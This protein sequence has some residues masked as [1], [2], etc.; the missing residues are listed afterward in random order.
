MRAFLLSFLVSIHI[1]ADI[2]GL[3]L[4]RALHKTDRNPRSRCDCHRLGVQLCSGQREALPNEMAFFTPWRESRVIYETLAMH[5]L[6]AGLCLD[7]Q[8]FAE[9]G[10]PL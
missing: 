6:K 7:N 3:S 10:T 8:N 1:M 2:G 9:S 5:T 4:F